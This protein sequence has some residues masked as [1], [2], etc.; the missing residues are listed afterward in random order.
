MAKIHRQGAAW[1][2][3]AENEE[4]RALLAHGRTQG[5]AV[6]LLEGFYSVQQQDA[7][8]LPSRSTASGAR[9]VC[10]AFER[11]ALAHREAQRRRCGF[12]LVKSSELS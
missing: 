7:L 1:F 6:T 12:R 8:V 10:A 9:R 5:G 3:V 4:E 2:V 11:A